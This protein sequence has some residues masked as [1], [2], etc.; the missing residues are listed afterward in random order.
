MEKSTFIFIACVC[1][2]FDKVWEM[3]NVL[4]FYSLII[5]IEGTG[6]RSGGTAKPLWNSRALEYIN[7]N[8]PVKKSPWRRSFCK[9]ERFLCVYLHLSASISLWGPG[10]WKEAWSDK[11]CVARVCV[12][13]RI[14]IRPFILYTFKSSCPLAKKFPSLVRRCLL[15]LFIFYPLAVGDSCKNINSPFTFEWMR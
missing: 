11:H 1:L 13:V 6:L 4:N 9:Y 14:H 2:V 8:W 15:S 10:V 3:E 12:C 5:N 7:A